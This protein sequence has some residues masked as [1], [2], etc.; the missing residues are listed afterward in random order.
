MINPCHQKETNN[1]LYA[2]ERVE[3]RISVIFRGSSTTR[4]WITNFTLGPKELELPACLKGR[5]VGF[6]PVKKPVAVHSGFFG[7]SHSLHYSRTVFT[8][9]LT[10]LVPL[11]VDYLAM[12]NDHL[13]EKLKTALEL[14]PGFDVVVTGHR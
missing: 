14:H 3:K 2:L 9:I 11:F 1:M 7:R 8:E 13:I 5:K 12:S 10:C 6:D 4:D